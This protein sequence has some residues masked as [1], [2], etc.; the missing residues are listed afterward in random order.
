M[1]SGQVLKKSPFG[2]FKKEGVLDY[3][4]QLE[5]ELRDA[6]VTPPPAALE[7]NAAYNEAARELAEL[8][9]KLNELEDENTVSQR[10]IAALTKQVDEYES[11]IREY[12]SRISELSSSSNKLKETDEKIGNLVTDAV[13]YSETLMA[14]ARS[15]SKAMEAQTKKRVEQASADVARAQEKLIQIRDDF[16]FAVEAIAARL[17]EL[18]QEIAA[19]TEQKQGN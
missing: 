4:E 12:E 10:M 16:E 2:G 5:S 3:I 15:N 18:S 11:R 9:V 1:G 17:S 14:R 7:R 19:I 6:R 8:E 13:V